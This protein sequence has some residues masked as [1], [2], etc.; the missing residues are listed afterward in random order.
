MPALS[1]CT[2][3]RSNNALGPS[4]VD[5][6]RAARWSRIGQEG[7]EHAHGAP[8][9]RPPQLRGRTALTGWHLQRSGIQVDTSPRNRR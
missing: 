7:A 2:T 8:L 5:P 4:T 1:M 3:A 9:H 6:T